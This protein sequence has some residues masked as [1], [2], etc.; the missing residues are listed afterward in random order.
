[1]LHERLQEVGEQD[2]LGVRVK[3]FE[4]CYINRP[5]L[6]GIARLC[7]LNDRYQAGIFAAT[8]KHVEEIVN[9][10]RQITYFPNFR[11]VRKVSDSHYEFLFGNGSKIT[12]MV[13]S[14]GCRGCRMHSIVVD[15]D[16][17]NDAINRLLRP[18]EIEY[19]K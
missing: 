2:R 8:I 3:M 16:V 11:R 1:M 13:P 7:A 4:I 6:L 9:I 15:Q 5:K 14:D 19:G 10:L 18:Y 17:N 12:V